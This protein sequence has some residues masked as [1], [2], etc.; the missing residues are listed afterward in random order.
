MASEDDQ[1]LLLWI[2]PQPSPPKPL[3][4][5]EAF[6]WAVTMVSFL[7]RGTQFTSKAFFRDVELLDAPKNAW[8][9]IILFLQMQ[10]LIRKVEKT[11]EDQEGRHGGL[12]WKWE[13]V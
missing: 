1:S 8:G 13:V 10:G 11:T 9:N 2:S 12:A 7:E 3:T 4:I 5:D 6:Q